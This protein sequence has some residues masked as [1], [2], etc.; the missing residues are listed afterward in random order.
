MT[1][2]SKANIEP[3]HDTNNEEDVD[4][5]IADRLSLFASMPDLE[6]LC[7]ANG[8]TRK[9]FAKR[10]G[11]IIVLEMFLGFWPRMISCKY[12]TN[13]KE[14]SIV[15]QP[16]IV[17][18]EGLEN[19]PAIE[20]LRIIECSLLRIE[21]LSNATR[22][23]YLNLSSNQISNMENL[24]KCTSLETLWLN[25]NRI[26][27]I[28]GLNDCINLKKLWVCKNNISKL[29]SGLEPCKVLDE[30]NIA[31]NQLSN[32]QALQPLSKL[33][34]LVSLSLSDP[35]YGDNPVCRLCNYQTYLLCQ[36]PQL[37]FLDTIELNPLNKQIADSTLM[38]KRMYYNM[39]IKTI[40]RNISN[41]LRHARQCY[42]DH[43]NYANFNLNA[44]M[45]ELSDLDKEIEDEKE[46]ANISTKFPKYPPGS[47]QTKRDKVFGYITSKTQFIHS[48]NQDFEQLRSK[49]ALLSEKT[50][51]RLFLELNT[52]GNIRLEDGTESDVWYASCVD[53]LKSRAFLS[54]LSSLGI[55]DLKVTRVT[56]VNNRFLRN[57]FQERVDALLSGPEEQLKENVSKRGVTIKESTS[58]RLID[59]EG[60]LKNDIAMENT[61]EYLFYTQPPILNHLDG[62]KEQYYAIEHG[63]RS[64]DE[65]ATL[66]IH[67]PHGMKLTNS[68]ALLDMP[69]I[70]S[71]YHANGY[72]GDKSELYKD[73]AALSNYGWVHSEPSRYMKSTQRKLMTGEYNLPEG[74]LVIA[75]AFVGNTRVVE[76]A[77]FP[78]PK[79]SLDDVQ[80]IQAVKPTDPKQRYY[81]LMDS[82]LALPEYIVEYEY[83][84]MDTA[85]QLLLGTNIKPPGAPVSISEKPLT[86]EDY[87]QYGITSDEAVVDMGAAISLTEAFKKSY[88][89]SFQEP[90]LEQHLLEESAK[91]L[92]QM[93]PTIMRRQ[94][95]G[96]ASSPI[97]SH[98]TE[99]CLQLPGRYVNPQEIVHLNLT[100]SGLKSLHGFDT[101]GLVRL[102]RLVLSFNEIRTIECLQGLTSLTTLDL[103]YNILRS[104]DNIAGLVAL[105]TLLLNNNLL[106]RF[107]D[108]CTLSR[109][110]QLT[111]LDLRNN[112]I[113]EAKRYRKNVLQRI[114]QLTTFDMAI[115]TDIELKESKELHV[116]LTPEKIWTS[117]RGTRMS[118]VHQN[119]SL[120]LFQCLQKGQSRKPEL[121]IHAA[122]EDDGGN[123]E[124]S[125]WWSEVEELHIDHESLT[126]LSYLEKLTSLRVASFSDNDISFIDGISQCVSLEELV[127]DNNQ[128]MTI[129]N[130]ETLVNLRVLDLSKN[131]LMSMK[132]LDTL[133]NLKQLSLEDNNITSLQGLSHLVKLMELYIGNNN[134]SNLKE[135]H[136]LK[137]LPKLIIVDFSG[138]GFCADA[139][140][141]LYTVYNLRRIKVLDGI[142]ITSELQY[143]A[144][145]KYSGKLTTDF[146]IEKI[147]HAFNRI[148]EMELSSC[149]IREIGSLHGDVF[150]NLKD[151]NLENNLISD[152]SGIEK[153]PKLRVLNLSSNRIERLTFAG[154]Y[155]GILA[156]PKLENLQLA[157]NQISDMIQLGLQH[158]QELKILNLEGNDITQIAGL[159]HAHE[160]KE[161]ILSKNKIRQFEAATTNVLTSLIVLKIDDNSLR[162]LVYFYP[163]SR[164]Q[165]L[166]LSNNRLPDLEEIERLQPL[167]P[168]VQELWVVNNPL[169]KRHLCRST[170]IY[171][172][173]SLKCLD[174]KDI[175][176]EERERVEV[177]FMH[178]RSMATPSLPPAISNSIAT[179]SNFVASSKTSVKL[180]AMSF[181]S[182]ISGQRRQN[183]NNNA[184]VGTV[185]P[186]VPIER[187]SLDSNSLSMES[188]RK[189]DSQPFSSLVS[190]QLQHKIA[191]R[192][193][194]S[195]TPPTKAQMIAQPIGHV[196][197]SRS[198]GRSNSILK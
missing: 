100:S 171:R 62:I 51:S 18:M 110:P 61:L 127:L 22:L 28:A 198:F 128:I 121:D 9:Q 129:E 87:R 39:R 160:L 45:R 137:S 88:Q 106:Y 44:L 156:C 151:L 164:L 97:I 15:K 170:I 38:K 193:E 167:I 5:T 152:I 24:S 179:S 136:H 52:G 173:S 130:F 144:K 29:D 122:F 13:L 64:I 94:A 115:V 37:T 1:I 53:L 117:S 46:L 55:R 34:S 4:Q 14:I 186:Q 157:N 196:Y 154:P 135:I 176:L 41:C 185:L 31:A 166:D 182:L 169:A 42:T 77:K 113:C 103:G 8:I 174:G 59:N 32:F 2:E 69:R 195:T 60:K 30:L 75:K 12:F 162:S 74:V 189:S 50:I 105:K 58:E 132:N 123:D 83:I 155:T 172:Y 33:P 86:I 119:T 25:D 26:D 190:S 178:D 126:T 197:T 111:T 145:Q 98:F 116:R 71:Q 95:I 114:P 147:G 21:G 131:K 70:A 16:T 43:L 56:R 65:Y 91:I 183:A 93:D 177:L 80:C 139:E 109:L 79:E 49:L 68:L 101:V 150:V 66:G 48:M 168:I 118:N 17:M 90:L 165:V 84:P 11:S 125:S 40:K 133:I 99:A 187:K 194:V 27:K 148:H 140:Y 102:E 78:L 149:R 47:L 73:L 175:T 67:C 161:L 107:D 3:E 89:L 63:F 184:V 35:H 10:A 112:A 19:C 143:E 6:E 188:R 158:L 163:L 134:I 142:S 108:V 120:A 7:N 23:K 141:T 191:P 146:L 192:P 104:I 76:N 180:T 20:T 92:I 82:A 181:E 72:Q 96:N 138:N 54:D 36:L 57:R 159:T 153:L 124:T 85:T 81:F